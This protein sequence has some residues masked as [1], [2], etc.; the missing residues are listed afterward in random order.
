P[1]SPTSMLPVNVL[2]PPSCLPEIGFVFVPTNSIL[3]LS[4]LIATAPALVWA[5]SLDLSAFSLGVASPFAGLGAA[6]SP[7]F[8][9]AGMRD[10]PPGAFGGV[11]VGFSAAGQPINATT[12]I[13][14]N[15]CR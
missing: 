8:G 5:G 15:N 3:V 4:G 10:M 12:G 14:N 11:G 9:N 2:K 1:L 6:S 7:A 13:N